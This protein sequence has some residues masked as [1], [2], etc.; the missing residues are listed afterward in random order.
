MWRRYISFILGVGIILGLTNSCQKDNPKVGQSFIQSSL[1]TQQDTLI[2]LTYTKR[3]DS[4]PASDLSEYL[5]GS[6]KDPVF[7]K[8]VASVYHQVLLPTKNV[9][10]GKY[11]TLDSVILTINLGS[12]YGDKTAAQSFKVYEVNEL[13]NSNTTYYSDQH[14]SVKTSPI[15][16]KTNFSPESGDSI[17]RIRLDDQFGK[18]LLDKSGTDVMANNENFLQYL[19]GLYIQPDTSIWG[20][21][22]FD[23]DINALSTQLTVY[24]NNHQSDDLSFSFLI[25]K[26]GVIVNRF[27]HNYMNT[28]VGQSLANN[29]DDGN[30]KIYAQGMAGVKGVIKFPNFTEKYQ[31]IAINKA[32]LTLTL[33][34]PPTTYFAPQQLAI[35]RA[36][37]SGANDFVP[38]QFEGASY[39]GGKKEETVINGKEYIQYKFNLAR[40]FQKLLTDNSYKDYG[41]YVVVFPSTTTA[42][43]A[44]I[45]GN[46]HTTFKPQ[47]RLTYTPL[48]N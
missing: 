43:R 20:K 12:Y 9:D 47:L 17:L 45:S 14:F 15:G 22:I 3:E 16:K 42:R 40:H 48:N 27:Q 29:S 8:T 35:L 24:Y 44:I 13:L 28:P 1:E 6:Y 46:L 31:D 26:T 18:R 39:Y 23:L 4:L 32:E 5:L 37:A 25:N 21:G 33:P 19:N 41:L 11:L 38:D 34:Q 10:L 30:K 7:G 2:P 36:D